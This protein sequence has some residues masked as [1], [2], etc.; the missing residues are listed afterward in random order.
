LIVLTPGET[1]PFTDPCTVIVE[2]TGVGQTGV[3]AVADGLI[4]TGVFV[5]VGRTGVF[6]GDGLTGVFVAVGRTGVFV[7]VGT[8]SDGVN[9]TTEVAGDCPQAFTASIQIL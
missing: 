4:V 6:V 7:G 2:A 9:V 5:A 8:V 1:T 3:V